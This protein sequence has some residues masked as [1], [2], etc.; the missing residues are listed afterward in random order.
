MKPLKM[1]ES[2]G[3]ENQRLQGKA[4]TTVGCTP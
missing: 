4:L 2:G 3:Q 1:V